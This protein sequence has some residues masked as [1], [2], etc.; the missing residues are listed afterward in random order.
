MKLSV[1]AY[2]AHASAHKKILSS[3]YHSQ[4]NYGSTGAAVSSSAVL[5]MA[6]PNE[7]TMSF[8]K[9]HRAADGNSDMDIVSPSGTSS[10]GQERTG[11]ISKSQLRSADDDNSTII[12]SNIKSPEQRNRSNQRWM[13]LRT[14]VQISSAIQKKPPLKREDSFLKRFSTR[15]IPEAQVKLA[16]DSKI[17]F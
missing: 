16:K 3:G 8:A 10:S 2:R 15:Q 11:A 4:L 5:Q 12:Y 7:A 9:D 1:S 6:D 13:K 14:T 17:L